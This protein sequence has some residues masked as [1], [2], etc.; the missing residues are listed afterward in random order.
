M[1][2]SLSIQ[3]TCY[4]LKIKNEGILDGEKLTC[5]TDR[6]GLLYSKSFLRWLNIIFMLA[7]DCRKSEMAVEWISRN[8]DAIKIESSSEN[9]KRIIQ[10]K[11]ICNEFSA[12]WMFIIST[13]PS[14]H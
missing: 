1:V 8:T 13:L 12:L 10:C 11:I 3:S 7:F 5:I 9:Y 6:I 2:L 4:I 14:M